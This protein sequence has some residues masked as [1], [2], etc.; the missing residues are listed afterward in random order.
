MKCACGCGEDAPIA[1]RTDRKRNRVKGE[2]LR[3]VHGHNRRLPRKTPTTKP[4]SRCRKTKAADAFYRDKTKPDGLSSYCIECRK[5]QALTWYAANVR[6]PNAPERERRRK[7]RYNARTRW[8]TRKH[9]VAYE[10][11]DPDAVY[12][13]DGGRCWICGRH[14]KRT[15][16]T[17]DHVTFL[18]RGGHHTDA[19]VRLAHHL[20]NVRRNH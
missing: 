18:A 15:D 17:L 10:E 6:D 8:R 13:R 2:P 14:V 5:K 20:C 4:C 12:Q 11:V 7:A 19:N 1:D 9:G 16:A 3:F